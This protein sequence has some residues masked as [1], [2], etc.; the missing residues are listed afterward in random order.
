M[1]ARKSTATPEAIVARIK[2]AFAEFDRAEAEATRTSDEFA[3]RMEAARH[4]KENPAEHLSNDDIQ[5]VARCLAE[6]A[7]VTLSLRTLASDAI[8]ND[9]AD[10]YLT[11]IMELARSIVRRLEACAA[12][13]TGDGPFGNFAAEFD[14]E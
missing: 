3:V 6:S 7:M 8:D 10:A 5:A 9:S 2:G 11:S 1:A 12:R 4:R 14:R 13:L